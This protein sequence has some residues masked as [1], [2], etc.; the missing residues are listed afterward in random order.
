MSASYDQNVQNA[1]L[2]MQEE[3]DQIQSWI[4]QINAD[5]ED[6]EY[7]SQNLETQQGWWIFSSTVVNETAMDQI[8]ADQ[9]DIENLNE[10][11]AEAEAGDS[12]FTDLTDSVDDCMDSLTTAENNVDGEDD[13]DDCNLLIEDLQVICQTMTDLVNAMSQELVVQ[14]DADEMTYLQQNGGSTA[15]MMALAQQSITDQGAVNTTL[16]NLRNYLNTTMQVY[17]QEWNDAD[18]DENGIHWWNYMGGGFGASARN[19]KSN[20]EAIKTNAQN[21]MDL[22]LAINANIAPIIASYTPD[23]MQ[24]TLMLDALMKKLAELLNNSAGMS[25]EEKQQSV[26]QL[27]S[28]VMAIFTMVVGLLTVVQQQATTDR[29]ESDAEMDQATNDASEM[30]MVNSQA[31]MKQVVQNIAYEAIMSHIMKG[32]EYAMQVLAILAAPGI[33]GVLVSVV[34]AA[35]EDSGVMDMLMSK[36]SSVMGG[37]GAAIFVTGIEMLAT[38]GGGAALDA[39]MNSAA[40]TATKSMVEKLSETAI[41]DAVESGTK[42]VAESLGEDAAKMAKPAIEQ[43]AKDAAEKACDKTFAA[44]FKQNGMSLLTGWLKEAATGEVGTATE[45]MVQESFEVAIKEAAQSGAANAAEVIIT[46]GFDASADAAE[47]LSAL[48]QVPEGTINNAAAKA[49]K[50]SVEDMEKIELDETWGDTAQTAAVRG[51]YAAAYGVGA[52]NVLIDLLN[53]CAK[54]QEGSDEDKW[55]RQ[56]TMALEILQA[57]LMIVAQVGGTGIGRGINTSE[58]TQ[59]QLFTKIANGLMPVDIGV[60]AVTEGTQAGIDFKQADATEALMQFQMMIDMLSQAM[61]PQ[62]QG[63]QQQQVQHDNEILVQEE[64]SNRE[65]ASHLY[66]YLNVS[67]Q[68]LMG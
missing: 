15:D 35:L 29:Q 61:A 36:L 50:M 2:A 65:M 19:E 10:E 42:K 38:M 23:F 22:C 58:A 9:E 18:T 3:Y 41:K 33:G 32:S 16:I 20:D 66:D 48:E 62:I 49:M 5:N 57:L 52:N 55:Y 8:E 27:N 56:L 39:A 45:R 46:V 4:D 11:I 6:I 1:Q 25:P 26:M 30:A 59:T 31:Q 64:K 14:E 34:L 24:I 13:I 17:N 68:V 37:L 53:A 63:R 43:A 12:T 7:Q 44:Y 47:L 40:Q 51:G 21:M 28:E 54:E 67:A 60:K